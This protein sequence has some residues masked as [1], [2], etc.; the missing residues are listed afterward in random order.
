[1]IENSFLKKSSLTIKVPAR[2][3]RE[4]L[5]SLPI[6]EGLTLFFQ[7]YQDTYCAASS[8]NMETLF[9]SHIASPYSSAYAAH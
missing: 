5:R 9:I 4:T 6:T 1:M 2:H 8:R 7:R 3:F